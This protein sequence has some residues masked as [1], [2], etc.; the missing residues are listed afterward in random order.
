MTIVATS[1]SV[2]GGTTLSGQ[3]DSSEDP[4]AIDK[5]SIVNFYSPRNSGMNAISPGGFLSIYRPESPAANLAD[6]D[7]ERQAPYTVAPLGN[8]QVF[9]GATPPPLQ[10][11]SP[12]R[13]NVIVPYS[14]TKY[15]STQIRVQRGDALSLP[16]EFATAVA[17][18]AVYQRNG[19]AYAYN[20]TTKA[21]IGASAPAHAG[22]VLTLYVI[23]LGEADRTLPDGSISPLSPPARVPGVS[24]DFGG[25]PAAVEFA[26]LTPDSVG[27][28]QINIVVPNGI[29]GAS[30]PLTVSIKEQ[31]SS[32]VKIPLE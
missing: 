8:A 19:S 25:K 10:F 28:Y 20:A 11:A 32:A 13:I 7:A 4:P 18:P 1:G 21:P 31:T 5:D 9:F 30:V 15:T 17:Q 24:V 29:S 26:G 22:D 16:V 12:G 3:S 23:G 27:L 14:V 6:F 2:S